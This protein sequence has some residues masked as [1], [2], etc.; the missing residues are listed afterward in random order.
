[1][2]FVKFLTLAVARRAS[3]SCVRA[4]PEHAGRIDTRQDR[5]DDPHRARARNP[6]GRAHRRRKAAR[7][8]KGAQAHGAEDARTR[9]AAD[10][11]L[12]KKERAKI[13]KAQDRQSKK[14]Y[15]E[16]HDKQAAK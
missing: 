4:N 14:I 12:T 5:Q 6:A 1:M 16:K 2:P 13:E 9:R 8:G 11:K 15:R 3:A 10:G 7:A